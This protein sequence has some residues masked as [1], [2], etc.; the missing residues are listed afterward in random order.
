MTIK[1]D[2]YVKGYNYIDDVIDLEDDVF[3]IITPLSSEIKIKNLNFKNFKNSIYIKRVRFYDSNFDV[4]H[5]SKVKNNYFQNS[6]EKSFFKNCTFNNCVFS[7]I[8]KTK[9]DKCSF[10]N[11]IFGGQF[12]FSTVRSNCKIENSLLILSSGYESY[13]F[14]MRYGCYKY[15]IR[16]MF[17][18][19]SD[20]SKR[21]KILKSLYFD[22]G[23]RYVVNEEVFYIDDV[24]S[25]MWCVINEK[26]FTI[27]DTLKINLTIRNLELN[28]SFY[29][30]SN[31]CSTKKENLNKKLKKLKKV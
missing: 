12:E 28:R 27:V 25:P 19:D 11:C 13:F 8:R 1:Y 20:D 4:V 3:E 2:N 6:V 21:Y 14:G 16:N 26:N 31:F 10:N 7:S 30:D 5:F 29:T 23:E 9:F 18:D 17:C 15:R 24:L 22:I